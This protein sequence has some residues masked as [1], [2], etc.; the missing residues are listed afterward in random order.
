MVL[1]TLLQDLVARLWGYNLHDLDWESGG[2][3]HRVAPEAASD[4]KLR[5]RLS[6]ICTGGITLMT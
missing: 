6:F 3:A 4:V 5:R 1:W 2:S